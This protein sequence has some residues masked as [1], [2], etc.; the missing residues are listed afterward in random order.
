MQH[1]PEPPLEELLWTVAAARIMFGPNMNIQAP[2][3]LTPAAAAG[4]SSSSSSSSSGEVD[5]SWR[6]LLDAGINDWGGSALLFMICF[7]YV[8][9]YVVIVIMVHFFL[10]LLLRYVV[11]RAESACALLHGCSCNCSTAMHTICSCTRYAAEGAE[12]T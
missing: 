4:S 10:N 3:N 8:V 11:R 5:A 6:A 1:H 7:I 9:F 2:P 12:S